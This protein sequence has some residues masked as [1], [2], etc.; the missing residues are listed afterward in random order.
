MYNYT[1]LFARAQLFYAGFC[2]ELTNK[3]EAGIMNRKKTDYQRE[4]DSKMKKVWILLLCVFFLLN[5]CACGEGETPIRR[6]FSDDTSQGDKEGELSDSDTDEKN[7]V[8]I[9]GIGPITGVAASYG[10][11]VRN[12]A[13]IAVDEINA[14][15]GI[16]GMQIKFL[17]ED[18]E[19]KADKAVSAYN[20]LMDKGMQILMGT[21][22][23]D[24]CIAVSEVAKEDNVFMI[25]PTGSAVDCIKYDNAF[26][27]CFSDPNQGAASAQYIQENDLGTKIAIIYD[28]SDVYSTGIKDKFVAKAAEL[29]LNIVAQEAFAGAYAADFS[30]QLQNVK[31]AEADLIFLPIYYEAAAQILM[32]AKQADLNVNFFGCDGLDGVIPQLGE[33][34]AVAEGVMLLTPFVA[35]APDA[36]TQAFTAKYEEKYNDTPIQFAADAYDAIYAIKAA[37]EKADVKGDMDVSEICEAITPAIQAIAR[38]AL[39]LLEDVPPEIASDIYDFGMMLTGGCAL[40]PGMREALNRETGLRVTVAEHPRDAVIRGIGRILN[41]PSLW[42]TPLEYRLK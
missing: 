5:L 2:V 3:G 26:R 27:I 41:Q 39:S 16:N 13:Q 8:T 38:T 35:D 25:T 40:M 31:S 4:G 21:V 10:I 36:K 28:I 30:A 19:H 17:F 20:R 22:T 15:G 11:A 33:N 37:C 34:A 32:Q 12:G 24:P 6:P 18:D 23:S 14:A 9:G 29:G 7:P 1:T 42:G